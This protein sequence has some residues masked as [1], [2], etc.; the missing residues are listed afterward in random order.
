MTNHTYRRG[1]FVWR[2]LMTSDLEAS[3]TFYNGLIGWEYQT[4][5]MPDGSGKYTEIKAGERMVGGMVPLSAIG[6][7]G[8]PPHWMPYVSIANI[9]ESAAAATANGGTV[10]MGPTTI[11]TVGRMTVISDAQHAYSSCIDLETGDPPRAE[12]LNQGEFCWEQLNTTDMDSAAAFYAKVYGWQA[13]DFPHGG[14]FR[15]FH[16]G[17]PSVASLMPAQGGAPAHWL[18]YVLV[19]NLAKARDRVTEFGG[20]IVVPEVA[21]PHVG[22]IGVITDNVGCYIGLFEAPQH[23]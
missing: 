7:D 6:K 17:E 23:G 8:V 20:Q 16:A 13:K 21:I 10:A 1:H 19:D 2:E 5:D 15:V 11:P 4:S 9:D 12:K 18:S 3:K 14:G 22:T